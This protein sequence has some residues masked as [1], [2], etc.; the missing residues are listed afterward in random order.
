MKEESKRRCVHFY[1]CLCAFSCNEALSKEFSY[2]LNI[3]AETPIGIIDETISID[4]MV[5]DADDQL[6]AFVSDT[7]QSQ[8]TEPLLLTSEVIADSKNLELII[9]GEVVISSG[10]NKQQMILNDAVFE[11]TQFVCLQTVEQNNATLLTVQ[12]GSYPAPSAASAMVCPPSVIHIQPVTLQRTLLPNLLRR[13]SNP[14]DEKNTILSFSEWLSSVTDRINDTM[15]YQFDG[16]PDPLVFHVPQKFFDCLQQRISSSSKKKRLPN[17][18]TAFVRKEALPLG[19]FTKYTWNITNI[20]HVKQ[21]FDTPERPLE[22]SRRFVENRDGS[23][24]L[25]NAP[26]ENAVDS[27][28]KQPIRPF[29]LKTFLKVGHMSADQ[30]DPPIPFTLEWIP[31][32][33]PKSQIGELR[34]RFQYG[35]ERNGQ[36]EQRPA[37]T[38]RTT[39]N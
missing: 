22:L 9:D 21:I 32:V 25:Y 26:K 2:Y 10:Q 17:H 11:D 5:T 31:D 12:E 14:I 18:A 7:Q 8:E 29:E 20:Q 36:A 34:M 37:A 28:G 6:I 24:D 15:H 38:S 39:S 35:H 33:L 23:F 13:T 4:Q 30:K 19:T 3:E 1:A 16:N 27:Y